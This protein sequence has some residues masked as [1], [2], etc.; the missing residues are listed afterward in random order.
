MFD[1]HG[2]QLLNGQV[3]RKGREARK[4]EPVDNTKCGDSVLLLFLLVHYF[5]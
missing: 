4:Q 2:L 1:C 5:Y 3:N